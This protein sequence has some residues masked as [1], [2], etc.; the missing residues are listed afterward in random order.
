M[1]LF[2]AT[3]ALAIL[4]P[5][6]GEAQ[7]ANQDLVARVGAY[8]GQF[9]RS[10]GSVVAE[11]RYEQAVR[12]APG[13]ST[14]SVRRGDNGPIATTLVSDFLL[15]QV[16]GEGWMPFRD[17]FERDGQQLRDREERLAKIFLG[18]SRDSL[19]Q[20]RAIMNESARYNIGNVQRNINMP[21]LA[22]VFLTNDQRPRF[23]F[24]IGK[25]EDEGVVIEFRETARPTF[26]K[27]ANDRD[28]PVNGRLWVDE[29]DGT[30]HK[31]ELHAVDT[32]V[33]AHITVTYTQ[34]PGL[35]VWVPSRME[36]RYRAGR[37]SLEVRGTATYS[38]FRR[39][40]VKTSE[41][42]DDPK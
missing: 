22:L 31:T 17:V 40:Q 4:S 3:A 23:S 5:L 8:V 24:K 18:G 42:I 35:G 13:S 34:D 16:P 25:S 19:D 9:Y 33:E 2:L 20:M 12:R 41:N 28:I 15:V 29:Q 36:E 27:T 11:E 30:I 39:F 7:L 26:I 32:N 6:A 14:T 21:T 38:K 10:F 1:R 37:D